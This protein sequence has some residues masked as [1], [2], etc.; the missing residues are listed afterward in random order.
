ML[1][2]DFTYVLRK[3]LA[4]AGLAPSEAA[5]RAGLPET[6]VMSFLRGIFHEE[7]ARK[8]AAV[9]GLNAEAFSRHADYQPHG[10]FIC[11]H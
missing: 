4:R 6:Q 11:E 8:L 9:L 7:A 10:D 5:A 3:A 1:E 2:D